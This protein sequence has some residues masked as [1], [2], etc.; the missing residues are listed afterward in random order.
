MFESRIVSILIIFSK[1]MKFRGDT[2]FI[3]HFESLRFK[4][5]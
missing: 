3:F 1:I 2:R 5:I 4:L